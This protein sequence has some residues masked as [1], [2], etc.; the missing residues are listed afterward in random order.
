MKRWYV[1]QI[2][3]GY[4]REIVADL[5]RRIEQSGQQEDFG[6]IV[7]A[8]AKVKNLFGGGSS[9]SDN[10]GGEEHQLF[11]GYLLVEMKADPENIRLVVGTPRILRFLGGRTPI[12]LAKNEVERVKAQMQG[13][14]SVGKKESGFV[15]GSEVEIADGPFSG[16]M[17]VIEEVCDD[18]EKLKVMVSI[19]GRM[20]PVELSFGQVSR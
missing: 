20:T 7:S 4:E 14:V 12:P 11:P 18:T 5:N 15:V 8:S 16:F 1:V 9:G 13:E 6:E 19:F 3:A 17:G 10:A 2:Y